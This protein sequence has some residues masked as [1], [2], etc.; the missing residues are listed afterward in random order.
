MTVGVSQGRARA[1][2]QQVQHRGWKVGLGS[3]PKRR[4]RLK[5]HMVGHGR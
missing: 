3:A 5:M 2:L 4:W 1:W